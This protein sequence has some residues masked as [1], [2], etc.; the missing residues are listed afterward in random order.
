[1]GGTKGVEPSLAVPQTAV[2]PLH[3]R[4]HVMQECVFIAVITPFKTYTL[5]P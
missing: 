3:Y 5:A 1:M 4:P 2:L